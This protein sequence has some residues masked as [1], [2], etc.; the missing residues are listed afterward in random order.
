M[1]FAELI[2]TLYYQ[3]KD[4]A[5]L[6]RKKYLYFAEELRREMQVDVEEVAED[7]RSFGRIAR[8]T[9]MEAGEIAAFIREVRPVVYGGRSISEKEMKRLVDKMN[10]IINHI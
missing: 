8:K 5:D 2:G 4:H 3:K 6:V 7:E 1:E 9:G 10:E